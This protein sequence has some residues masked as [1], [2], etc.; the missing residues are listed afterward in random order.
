M[1]AP[2]GRP[3]GD[4]SAQALGLVLVLGVLF[5]VA[6]VRLAQL[7]LGQWENFRM[8]SENNSLRLKVAPAPRGTIVDRRGR[9]LADSRATFAITVDAHR[10]GF[11]RQPQLLRLTLARLAPILGIP[12]TTLFARIESERRRSMR[13]VTVALNADLA[14]LARI[15]EHRDDLPGV[16]VE[17]IPERT[18]PYGTA[19]AHVLGYSS[20]ITEIQL[21]MRGDAYDPGDLV[22]QAGLE[23]GYEEFLRGRDGQSLVEVSALGRVIGEMK[24]RP[25]RPPERGRTLQLT[26]D[27]NVQQQA[28]KALEPW[29]RG[30]VVALDPQTGAILA[31][32][33]KPAFDPN[34]F[35]R[36]LSAARWREIEQSRTFPL[37][38]RAIQSSYPPGSTFK[39]VTAAAGLKGGKINP[40]TRMMPCPGFFTLGHTVFHCWQHHGHGSLA[41]RDAI[42]RS[43]DVYFYQ[44][45]LRVGV[46]GI[47]DEARAAGLGSVTGVD[48]PGEKGGFVPSIA[49]Y[50]KRAGRHGGAFRGAAVN[51]SIG[52]GE[53]LLTPLQIALL[54]AQV[55]TGHRVEPYLVES[56]KDLEGRVIQ[57]HRVSA[58]PN[59]LG[60]DPASLQ[61][62]RDAM[63][64][65]VANPSGTGGRARVPG[66]RVAGKTGTAQNPHG[67]DHGVF[68][69]FA[70]AEHPR[71]AVGVVIENGEHGTNAAPVARRIIAAYLAPRTLTPEELAGTDST[72]APEDTS[73]TD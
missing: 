37:L 32:A 38:D 2:A 22:G 33:S 36:G 57:K 59:S 20:Q 70:P 61:E 12:D 54:A 10:P 17:T 44:V 28:E 64:S 5:L 72:G 73:A 46:D 60:L 9:V 15:E 13:P 29:E 62:L 69:A 1:N 11:E 16:E 14:L 52:Q 24:D 49:W 41:L 18:Y 58:R 39:L 19:A 34:E 55:G 45:G 25:G 65:V 66:I 26:L 71:I 47:A 30:A 50:N 7:Q 21:A 68:M 6:L 27:L 48:L 43:C 35:S 40:E 63:E 23:R 67:K 56:I 8:L 42:T 51:I 31:L 4:R 3:G 53:M